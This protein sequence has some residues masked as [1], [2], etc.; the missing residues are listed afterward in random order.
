MEPLTPPTANPDGPRCPTCGTPRITNA[1]EACYRCAKLMPAYDGVLIDK[2]GRAHFSL[3]SNPLWV[4]LGSV[5]LVIY[6]LALLNVTD[7]PWLGIIMAVL[8]VP[9]L[10]TTIRRSNQRMGSGRPFTAGEWLV[11]FLSHLGIVTLALL[12]LFCLVSITCLSTCLF[13]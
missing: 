7:A 11:T 1:A 4:M 6:G 10:F 3:G 8:I 9:P 2:T 12:S 5:Y 13:R